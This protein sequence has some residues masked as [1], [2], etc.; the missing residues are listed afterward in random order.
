MTFFGSSAAPAKLGYAVFTCLVLASAGCTSVV[1]SGDAAGAKGGQGKVGAEHVGSVSPAGAAKPGS[2]PAGAYGMLAA[3][4]PGT[5]PGTVAA[6]LALNERIKSASSNLQLAGVNVG[7]ARSG[8]MPSVYGTGDLGDDGAADA[9]F[10]VSQP[11]LD[12]GRTKADVAK[13]RAL[14]TASKE[15]LAVERERVALEAA[16]AYIGVIRSEALLALAKD[17][18]SALERIAELAQGLAQG[19]LGD[20]SNVEFANVHVGEAGATLEEAD[21]ALVQAR[22]VYATR[23]GTQPGTLASLPVIELGKISDLRAAVD[24]APAVVALLARG[25]AAGHAAK[26]AQA[27]LYPTLAGEAFVRSEDNFGGLVV[28]A[29]L[30]GKT[31]TYNGA[32]NLMR[33]EAA[34]L[35]S[36]SARSAAD[37]ERRQATERVAVFQSQ[38]PALKERQTILAKQ[39]E[40]AR[41][42]RTTYEEQFKLNQRSLTDLVTVQGDVVRIE[43]SLITAK[44][45]YFNLQYSAAEALGVLLE[46]LMGEKRPAQDQIAQ[47]KPTAQPEKQG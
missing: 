43:R 11:L 38:A 26:T 23:V 35:A 3:K 4:A 40:S 17:N 9:E 24:A 16:Q 19:G 21:G 2:G 18:L 31:P 10:V 14:E 15:E 44:Y 46:K 36:D 33:V 27:E 30:R 6:A 29:R 42:L 28:G 20:K 32:S 41:A 8:Y 12:W 22:S 45:D 13:A 1:Q 7:I 25:E 5:L 47:P 39:L 37:A 34:E